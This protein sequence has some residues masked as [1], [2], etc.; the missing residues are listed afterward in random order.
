MAT[1]ETIAKELRPEGKG[2][3]LPKT[4]PPATER[5]V[6]LD[7]FRGFIMFWIIGGDALALALRALGRNPVI[8]LLAYE[9]NHT[10]WR[11]LR[12]Y[13]CIWPSFMLMAG[14]SIPFAFAKRSLTETD[15][16]IRMHALKRA[17]VLFLLGSVRE[18][19][20]LKS[21]FLIEL[22]SALQ[23]IAIAYFIGALLLRKP[24]KVLAIIAGSI[25]AAYA[26]LV[27]LVPAPGIAAGT[28]ELNHNLVNA[29][30]LHFLRSHWDIWPYAPEGWGTIL[31][32]IP[33]VST[34]LFGVLIGKLLMSSDSKQKKARMIGG[35]GV[36]LLVLGYAL[37]P[38]I[39]IVMKMWTSSYGLVSA[40]W[41]CLMFLLFFWLVDMRGHR[42]WTLLFV[43]IGVNPIFIYMATSILPIGDLVGVFTKGMAGHM[44]AAG[45]AFNALSVLVVEWVILYWMHTRR[46]FIKA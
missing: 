45:E 10:P 16:Q 20:F 13:D 22:S 21:P 27:A 15:H 23:P 46:I 9:V 6:S 1:S 3:M 40:G 33:T 24:P 4:A 32:T 44:G 37:S 5:L 7:T 14:I 34:T 41:A 31:S 2:V 35:L 18:S 8:N 30:D 12:F 29:V 39:P 43:V 38:V 11:G 17:L 25:L 19:V 36:L 26:L 42:K 28:Y